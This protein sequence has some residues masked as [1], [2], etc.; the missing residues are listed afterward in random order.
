M[1]AQW[2]CSMLAIW[3]PSLAMSVVDTASDA[4]IDV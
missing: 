4:C 1:G 2:Q 3:V